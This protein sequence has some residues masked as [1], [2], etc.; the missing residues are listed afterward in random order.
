MQ[1]TTT[2]HS[3]RTNTS[4]IARHLKRRERM[5]QCM[6]G[7]RKR[8]TGHD[9]RGLEELVWV[10]VS[11]GRRVGDNDAQHQQ[12]HVHAHGAQIAPP[13]KRPVLVV[14]LLQVRALT[15]ACPSANMD[16]SNEPVVWTSLARDKILKYPTFV[17][18][19][20]KVHIQMKKDVA[21]RKT[22]IECCDHI[23]T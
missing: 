13:P 17:I 2:G 3:I 9:L 10:H 18:N 5:R 12:Q 14:K 8:Q 4:V 15:M 21:T 23:H 6:H 1:G 16:T 20:N 7:L 19:T 11:G 22:S